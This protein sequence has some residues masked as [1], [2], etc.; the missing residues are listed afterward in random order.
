MSDIIEINSNWENEV[1]KSSIP[2]LVDFWAE[3]C[4]PCKVISPILDKISEE[5][6]GKIK[7]VK[8]NVD[9]NM[10]LVKKYSVRSVPTIIV[11]VDG[12]EQ[13]RIIG[14]L[15]KNAIMQKIASHISNE[16]EN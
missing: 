5:L 8:V 15:N 9:D 1:L 6:N 3:W 12:E 14:A 11:F 7:I 4:S 10:D 2:V 16:K 13:E